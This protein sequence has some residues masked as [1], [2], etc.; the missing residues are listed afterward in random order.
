MALKYR[1]L[2]TSL[3][4]TVVGGRDGGQRGKGKQRSL[5][6]V[7]GDFHKSGLKPH[8]IKTLGQKV[9]GGRPPT[10][11]TLRVGMTTMRPSV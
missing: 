6:T 8:L 3:G 11:T 7:G 9:P 2:S 5:E 10:P 1:G 4:M